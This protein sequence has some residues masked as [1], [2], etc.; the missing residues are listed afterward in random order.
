MGGM[1][2]QRVREVNQKEKRHRIRIS[3]DQRGEKKERRYMSKGK[4][5]GNG[6]VWGERGE[7][8]VNDDLEGV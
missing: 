7:E 3:R 8:D 5:T 4:W 2:Q 1:Y 6:G